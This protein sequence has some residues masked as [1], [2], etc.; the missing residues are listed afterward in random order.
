MRQQVR[1]KNPFIEQEIFL[2]RG[3]VAGIIMLGLALA[4][5]IKL[6]QLQ[7]LRHD[8][9]LELSQGN[10]VRLE[11]I[12]PARGLIRD[13]NG[14]VLADN[15]PA[16]QLELTL[17]ELPL[18]AR[19]QPDLDGTLARLV[20]IRAI[21]P[22]GVV[23]LK[24]LIRSRRSFEG[25]PIR[26]RLSDEDVARFAVHRHEFPGVEIQTRLTRN[27]RYGLIA[28]HALGY[29]GA[30]NEQEITRIDPSDYA[31]LSTIGKLGVELAYESQLRG[32]AGFRQVLVNAQGRAVE[33]QGAFT[34]KLETRAPLAGDDLTLAMD[35]NAQLAAEAAL[36]GQRGAVVALDPGSGDVIAFASTPNY[37]PNQFA[38]GISSRD[39]NELAT[40]IDRPLFN[41]AIRGAYPPGSTVKPLVAI[42]GLEMPGFDPND[43]RYCKG[44][45][46]LPG[47]SHRYRDWKKEGHGP[48]DMHDA[49]TQ[50]C[51]VYFYQ[52]ANTVGIERLSQLLTRFGLGQ[53]TGIDVG[54]EK[55]GLVPSPEWKRR[56][57][58]K[59][60]AQTWFPGET[61]IVGIG[62]GFLLATPLQ[63]ATVAAKIAARG[64]TFAPRMV[65][66]IRDTRTGK[67]GV[68]APKPLAVVTADPAHWDIVIGGMVGVTSFPKGT[69]RM[70]WKDAPYSVAGK[71]GTAQVFSLGQNEKY[72]EKTLEERLRDHGVFI[73]FA[74][75]DKARIAVAVLVENGRSGSGTAAP[76]A[77]KVMDA[78]LLGK[79]P[80]AAPAAPPAA[81]PPET[82]ATE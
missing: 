19:K 60:E 65:T 3:F 40:S 72:D 68:L 50:S 24:R 47:S 34:P 41:R 58:P 26:Q 71:S 27:Y 49:I 53:V 59:G 30:I 64:R 81:P 33:R 54:G 70:A 48:V 2:R 69:A 4:L 62:Q 80:D 63:L 37:D 56:T 75:A 11:P 82:G 18:D 9:Y 14:V 57:F 77:R 43:R 36:A 42:A 73:A 6:F 61:V 12:P 25:V 15:L 35:I 46:T 44:F 5:T 66:A 17:E 21:E 52:V 28:S 76:V 31:G 20:A 32:K 55:P 67:T 10:R 79:M 8:Y 51:D 39:Y 29:V 16:F 78:Y 74:P 45:Y 1:I 38:K 13:R 23:P 22:D 7:I